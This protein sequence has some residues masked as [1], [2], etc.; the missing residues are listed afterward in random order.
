M[1]SAFY[2]QF[3]STA[4]AP[5]AIGANELLALRREFSE[6]GVREVIAMFQAEGRQLL[7]QLTA[8]MIR[9]DW[10]GLR[11]SAHALRGAGAN[12]GAKP[13]EA[14]CQEIEVTVRGGNFAS[15]ASLLDRVRLEYG[16]VELALQQERHPVKRHD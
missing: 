7:D 4:A 1:I 6:D 13:L 14:L 16:R 2:P 3:G 11:R 5:N 12:F 15:V 10:P 8:A 9:Q